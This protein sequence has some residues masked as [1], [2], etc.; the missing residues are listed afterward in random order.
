MPSRVAR[1]FEPLWHDSRPQAGGSYW[2]RLSEKERT[3]DFTRPVAESMRTVRALGLIECL[4]PLHG[5]QV[6]VRRAVAWHEAHDYA[7]GQVVH[8]YRRWIVIAAL[9]G[10]VAL[11][12]WSPFSEPVRIGMQG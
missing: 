9:D 10:F 6:Y 4:A 2:P 3:L 7:P 8:Q 5:T 12:E 11:I 1:D